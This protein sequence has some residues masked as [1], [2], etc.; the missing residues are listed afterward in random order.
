MCLTEFLSNYWRSENNHQDQLDMKLQH[1]SRKHF[2]TSP[3]AESCQ[4]GFRTLQSWTKHKNTIHYS[5]SLAPTQRPQQYPCQHETTQAGDIR[6]DE[7]LPEGS[8]FIQ[9]PILDGKFLFSIVLGS[10]FK[11]Y[12][13]QV[14]H[15]I[16]RVLIYLLIVSPCHTSAQSHLR[17]I[18]HGI[19]S[20]ITL[21]INL[22]IFYFTK[23]KHLKIKQM[24]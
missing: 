19:H 14:H 1:Q 23:T 16:R 5:S 17:V 21:N 4:K 18:I 15:V 24:T 12:F 6:D 10:M 11:F 8:F 13:I 2:C 20:N 22:L 7:N 3:V 9:H